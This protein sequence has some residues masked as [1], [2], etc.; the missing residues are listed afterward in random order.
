[1]AAYSSRGASSL[2]EALFAGIDVAKAVFWDTLAPI[3]RQGKGL[4]GL[5]DSQGTLRDSHAR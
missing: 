2:D 4:L 1:M 3:N 5:G